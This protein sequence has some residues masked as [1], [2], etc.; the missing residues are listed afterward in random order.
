MKEQQKLEDGLFLIQRAVE[1]EDFLYTAQ[2]YNGLGLF[3]V[4][5]DGVVL[6]AM[7]AS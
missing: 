7:V 6:K 1:K 2:R 3:L 4:V 5:E